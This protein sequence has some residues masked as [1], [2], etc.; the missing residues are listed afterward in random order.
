[1]AKGGKLL[2]LHRDQLGSIVAITDLNG[3]LVEA[4]HFDAWGKI[5]SITDGNSNKLDK[6][7]LD[8]GY[9][10]HEH[11]ASV[12]LIHMNGRLYDP[13]LHRFLMPDNYIQDPFN[14][15]NFN[16]YGYCLNNPLVYVDQD[17]EWVFLVAALI[18]AY[19]GGAQANGTYNPFKWN[20]SNADTW[21]GITGGAIIGVASAGV[22][23][24]V[25]GAVA[26][27]L[28][29]VGISGGIMGGAIAG[30]SGGIASGFISGGFMS[31]LPGGNGKF[32]ES[33][34]WGAL[35]GF[36]G[37]AILGGATG[38]LTTPKGHN[39]W[40]GREIPQPVQTLE[41]TPIGVHLDVENN[42][43]GNLEL[44][45]PTS[46][47]LEIQQPKL[48]SIET[49]DRG[50]KLISQF[51]ENSID[52]GVRLT[53]SQKELHI[54]ANKL[55][56]KPWLNDLSTKMGGNQNVIESILRNVSGKIQPNTSGVFQVSTTIDGIQIYV[57]G[58]I[59]QGVPIINT[60]YIPK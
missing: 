31:G 38:A 30:A 14:T 32:W 2:F 24:A 36:V 43:T 34:G 18:G 54:F 58:Y 15:Q 39:I 11:L 57:R 1:M 41:T 16:R 5:L 45:A 22:G 60:V 59:N 28:A 52:K 44:K 10:G 25:G 21:M 33:A 4:R 50:I 3:K 55:H 17:G 48:I 6:L 26:A 35:S 46:V 42:I 27:E 29:A 7:L 19:I 37:G 23:I 12:G 20:Y 8:R 49:P 56:P 51:S 47:S 9:T 13:A 53:M 40:T